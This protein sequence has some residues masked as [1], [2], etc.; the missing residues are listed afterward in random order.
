MSQL[1][2]KVAVVR[3]MVVLVFVASDG[4]YGIRWGGCTGGCFGEVVVLFWNGES[5]TSYTWYIT[6]YDIC[7]I[8]L[9]WWCLPVVCLCEW[10]ICEL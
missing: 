10:S 1:Q 7:V 2:H 3:E 4:Y 6:G 5:A 8:D 9:L